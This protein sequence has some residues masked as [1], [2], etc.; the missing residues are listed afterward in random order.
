M[1]FDAA[2]ACEG[3]KFIFDMHEKKESP[4]KNISELQKFRFFTTDHIGC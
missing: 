1:L 3:R 2:V 4:T